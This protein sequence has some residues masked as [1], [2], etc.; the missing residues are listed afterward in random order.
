[1]R[2]INELFMSIKNYSVLHKNFLIV[3]LAI[4]FAISIASRIPY[5]NI[6]FT[7]SITIIVYWLIIIV[8]FRLTEKISLRLVLILVFLTQIA[9][10]LSQEYLAEE[11][12]NAIFFILLIGFLQIFWSY[13][14]NIKLEND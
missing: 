3:S 7:P 9:I 1:M 2:K 4:I 12:G 6:I 10:L 8:S 5:L 14:K 13:I 11:F